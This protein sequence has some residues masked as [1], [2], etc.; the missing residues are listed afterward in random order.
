MSQ[1]LRHRAALRLVQGKQPQHSKLAH[2]RTALIGGVLFVWFWL[3]V[4]PL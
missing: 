1:A 4:L 3:T 2:R